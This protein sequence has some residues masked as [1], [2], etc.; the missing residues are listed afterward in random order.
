MKA[1]AAKVHPV[2]Q[3]AA[4]VANGEVVLALPNQQEAV[5]TLSAIL[6]HFS[7]SG[8]NVTR[9]FKEEVKIE[10]R[11]VPLA[12]FYSNAD[13]ALARLEEASR[14][15]GVYEVKPGDSAWKIAQEHGLALSRLA[16]ANPGVDLNRVRAGARLK[17]PGELPPITVLAR[18]EIAEPVGDE[19]GAPTRRVR[20]SYENGAEVSRQV[21]G[22]PPR[23][24]RALPRSARRYRLGEF[25]R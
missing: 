5:R 3:A 14:P 9:Y 1:L 13:A 4:I 2:V 10:L 8:D 12:A 18:K 22:R 24:S 19:P 23:P 25:I 7:P 11:S 17:I 16:G 15:K 21:I 20:I 6:Q